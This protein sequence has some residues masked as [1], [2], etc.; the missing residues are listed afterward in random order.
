LPSG[1]EQTALAA[2]VGEVYGDFAVR[3]EELSVSFRTTY[4]KKPTLKKALIRL[5]R[6]QRS[7]REMQALQDVS[8]D[9][10]PR[11]I[12]GIVGVNGAG[13]S[14]LMRAVAG[15]LPP[16][17]GRVQVWG[18]V[19]T[20]L[21]LGVGFNADLS[22]RENVVL[23][24]LAAGLTREQIEAKYDDIAAFADLEE[25]MDLPMRAYSSGMF[26]RLAFS[27][28]VHTDPDILL[29]DEA[30]SVGDARFKHKCFE[31]IRAITDEAQAIM[32]VSHALK[33]ISELCTDVVWL[34]KGRIAMRDEPEPVIEA[35][36]RFLD[37][38][39]SALA[40]EDV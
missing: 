20:L 36:T 16:S 18:R 8:F 40:L 26:G 39:E 15:I 37:V 5:G 22:G 34:H 1:S 29:I 4:E 21:A 33:S 11:T 12:L 10:S 13:K 23:G 7:V 3:V 25:V 30:L 31:K 19:S 32:I 9:V 14:T 35:Y 17:E 2:P 27:V 24:G 6:R 38:G 28:A